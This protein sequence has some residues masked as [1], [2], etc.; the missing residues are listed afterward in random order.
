MA[1]KPPPKVHPFN[2]TLRGIEEVENFKTAEDRQRA[3]TELGDEVR[4]RDL[5][6]GIT[7]CVAAALGSFWLMR[8]MFQYILPRSIPAWFATNACYAAGLIGVLLTMRALHRWGAAKELR[9]KLIASGV[10]VC[11]E[12]GYRLEGVPP[13]TEMC[14]ECGK[15]IDASVLKLLK[16]PTGE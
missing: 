11:L 1:R 5:A 16:E 4:L 2:A 10:P 12:C 7:L 9:R 14:P 15:G 8:A 6:L 3:L 13:R